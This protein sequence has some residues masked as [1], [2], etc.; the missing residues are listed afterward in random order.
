M[1]YNFEALSDRLNVNVSHVRKDLPMDI[2]P[3]AGEM[4]VY[5]NSCPQNYVNFFKYL[6]DER[7]LTDIISTIQNAIR[8]FHKERFRQVSEKIMRSLANILEFK[9]IKP[10]EL[11]KWSRD[12]NAVPGNFLALF[13]DDCDIKHSDLKKVLM[14]F[15]FKN[16]LI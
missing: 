8:N 1:V 9:Y 12:I 4:F 6:L 15:T 3:I 14:F 2:F 5:L 11:L 16:V 13:T 7:P 10:N